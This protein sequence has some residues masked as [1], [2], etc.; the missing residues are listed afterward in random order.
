MKNFRT[1]QTAKQFYQEAK[2]LHFQQPAK[3]Q[4]QRALLSI[5]LNLAEGSGKSTRRDRAKFYAIALGSIREVQALLD[6][7]GYKE[8][9]DK[10]DRLAAMTFCLL[11]NPGSLPHCP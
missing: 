5:C 11:R 8:A 10:A 2:D 3:D 9:Y 1:Y 4:F 6:L 7:H